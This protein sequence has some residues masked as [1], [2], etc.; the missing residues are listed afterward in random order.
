MPHAARIAVRQI[1]IAIL[2]GVALL[3]LAPIAVAEAPYRLP[4][5]ISDDVEALNDDQHAEVQDAIDALYDSDHV[6]LWVAFVADFDGLGEQQWAEQ[7]AQDSSL[8]NSDVLLAVATVDGSYYLSAP[9]AMSAVSESEWSDLRTNAI[10]PALREEDWAGASIAT[11]TGIS[12]ALHSASGGGVPVAGVLVALGVVVV[13]AGGVVVF[14]R[15]RRKATAEAD[16]TAART[17]DPLD[18]DALAALPIP[19][20]HERSREVLVEMDNAVRTSSEELE[21]ARGEFGDDAVRVFDTA[22]TNAKTALA[23]AFTIRQ[24]LD[25][26]IPD[27]LEQQ[28]DLLVEL[29]NN[30]AR[31]DRELD[32]RVA[33]FDG[34]RD[35]LIDAP[36]RLDALT[37]RIVEVTVRIPASESE[38]AELATQFPASVLEPVL[39]N[40]AMARDQC[41]FAERSVADGR[42][43]IALP[44]GKQGA[45]V[46]AIRAAEAAVA[47]AG[48]LLD[49][50]DNAAQSI[51]GAIAALPA[52]IDEVR[53][54][55]ATAKALA[56]GETNGD[57]G[58]AQSRVSAESA[59]ARAETSCEGNPLGVYSQLLRADVELD[60]A[61][62]TAQDRARAA[63]RV[64]RQLDQTVGA[65]ASQIA[66]ATD[67]ISTRRGAVNAQARTRLAEGQRRLD[68]ARRLA[69]T[70]PEEALEHARAAT[71]LGSRALLSAQADVEHW[72]SSRQPVGGGPDVGAVLGGVLIDSI[73]RGG[74]AGGS[75]GRRYG[76]GGHARMGSPG[77][78]GGAGSS[79]RIG[80][81]GRF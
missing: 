42:T 76:S 48:E 77:S 59:L 43:A 37:Q 81:G 58:L 17:V 64:Q 71:E 3:G 28:R 11:A 25:D 24:Q 55:I 75:P 6:R 44:P 7:T 34:M 65:A 50:V 33:E 51:R 70:E 56:T 72:E 12:D 68:E 32:E 69:A 57:T 19:M 74:F 39:G 22:L 10:E 40:T 26:A 62:A 73:L 36:A 27:P 41:D 60:R 63:A 54:E 29:I 1:V 45:A 53:A 66:A 80:G 67:F 9:K 2:L 61:I 15:R 38:L 13:A 79:R 21:L 35:L 18:T 46:G 14:L 78:F 16:A 49:A 30:C 31:A 23:H 4:A 5:Q 47:H 20:L 8:G 52:L